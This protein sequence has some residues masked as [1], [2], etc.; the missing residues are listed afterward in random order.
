MG[1][2]FRYSFALLWLVLRSRIMQPNPKDGPY[3]TMA[4]GLLSLFCLNLEHDVLIIH[5]LLLLVASG[6]SFFVCWG[7][8]GSRVLSGL[9]VFW[10][11]GRISL[12]SRGPGRS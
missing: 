10:V 5:L 6:C 12:G 1:L 9:Q 3:C 7:V 4:P 8:G 2:G 11:Q